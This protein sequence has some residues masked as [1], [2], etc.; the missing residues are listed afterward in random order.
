M[1]KL[2]RHTCIIISRSTLDLV[3]E[4]L[5]VEQLAETAVKGKTSAV[6]MFEVV[7][8]RSYNQSLR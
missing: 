7:C 1:G 6:E 5:V 3:K 4:H 8:L 2:G